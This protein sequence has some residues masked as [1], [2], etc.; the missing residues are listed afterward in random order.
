ME[1]NEG[2]S[3]QLRTKKKGSLV[4]QV[5]RIFLVFSSFSIHENENM[6]M[7]K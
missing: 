4:Q 1:K 2:G 3:P 6:L 5:G 7:E